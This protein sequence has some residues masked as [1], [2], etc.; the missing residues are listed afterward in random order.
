MRECAVLKVKD[1]WTVITIVAFALSSIDTAKRFR[2]LFQVSYA[3][4]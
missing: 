4:C 2:F 1:S 3:H